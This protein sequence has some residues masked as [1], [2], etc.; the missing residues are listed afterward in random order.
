MKKTKLPDIETII[1]TWD[2]ISIGQYDDIKLCISILKHDPGNGVKMVYGPKYNWELWEYED[3]K[4]I[5]FSISYKDENSD[6]FDSELIYYSPR[7][8]KLSINGVGFKCNSI[9]EAEDLFELMIKKEIYPIYLR[10]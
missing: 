7:L 8:K 6:D 4:D 3:L 2:I 9:K 10:K 5:G 1:N